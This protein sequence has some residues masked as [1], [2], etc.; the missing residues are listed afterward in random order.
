MVELVVTRNVVDIVSISVSNSQQNKALR[1]LEKLETTY[2][3]SLQ[4]YIESAW[5][6]STNITNHNSKQKVKS[7]L[8]FVKTLKNVRE[9]ASEINITHVDENTRRQFQFHM[10]TKKAKNKTLTQRRS[11]TIQSEQKE[12]KINKSQMNNFST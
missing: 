5:T 7:Y 6:F 8:E 3:A 12:T 11:E 4:D 10:H 9:E 2:L 1:F